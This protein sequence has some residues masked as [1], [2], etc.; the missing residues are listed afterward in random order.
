MTTQTVSKPRVRRSAD[1]FQ[2][3]VESHRRYLLS[4]CYRML[5]SFT[6]AEDVLQEVLLRAWRGSEEFHGSASMRTWLYRIATNACLTQLSKRPR[7]SIPELSGPA[8]SA[9][10]EIAQPVEALH[11]IEPFPDSQ[12]GDDME[13]LAMRKESVA[14]AFVLALQHLAPR[15]RAVLL[16][17][18]VVGYEIAEIATMLNMTSA[19]VNSALARA[20]V[21]LKQMA[22]LPGGGHQTSLG[23][24]D[25]AM[26]KDYVRAWESAD[27]STL[28]SLLR[29]DASFSM[30]PIPS[31]AR[32]PAAIRDLLSNHVF[33][34]GR[35]FRLRPT[36]ANGLPAFAIYLAE[37]G[38]SGFHAHAIQ[39]A[40]TEN[41][42][43][44]AVLSFLNP[45]LVIDFGLPARI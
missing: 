24:A 43:I 4:H 16:L 1:P 23:S 41:G 11:W 29:R 31:W 34:N 28:V 42:A 44:S 33:A 12:L 6:E 22:E 5:G 17:R 3:Q 9:D 14:L 40:W 19:G 7:R 2:L 21:T 15:Q 20:R 26:L 10:D 39:F 38:H 8:L 45:R 13:S 36:Q 35:Q 18:E 30:P 27:V 25:Q 32:G 37:K